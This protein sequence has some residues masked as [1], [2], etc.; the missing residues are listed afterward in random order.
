[1]GRTFDELPVEGTE[2]SD[3]P[4]TNRLQIFSLKPATLKPGAGVFKKL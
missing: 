4:G 3:I 2:Y 1:M